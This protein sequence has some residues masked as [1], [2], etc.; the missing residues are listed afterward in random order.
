MLKSCR[1]NSMGSMC[2]EIRSEYCPGMKAYFEV[3]EPIPKL[4]N[5]ELFPVV[6]RKSDQNPLYQNYVFYSEQD[7]LTPLLKVTEQS[8]EPKFSGMV[9]L[10]FMENFLTSLKKSMSAWKRRKEQ[11]RIRQARFISDSEALDYGWYVVEI[12]VR[13][14]R[15]STGVDK[16]ATSFVPQITASPGV[17]NNV[18]YTISYPLTT[19]HVSDLDLGSSFAATVSLA[20]SASV[21]R[22]SSRSLSRGG[23]RG[24]RG[25]ERSSS[26][27]GKKVYAPAKKYDDFMPSTFVDISLDD[28]YDLFA[29]KVNP[30]IFNPFAMFRNKTFSDPIG[31]TNTEYYTMYP[32]YGSNLNSSF[33]KKVRKQGPILSQPQLIFVLSYSLIWQ[34]LPRQRQSKFP[35]SR[36]R[37]Y[38]MS[39]NPQIASSCR[40]DGTGSPFH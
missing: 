31:R 27:L 34:L 36:K 3:I 16:A 22:R 6:A 20:A 32:M 10:L 38:F 33:S 2:Q 14:A 30:R 24:G 28:R 39:M 18:V 9:S 19:D 26:G 25:L 29:Q 12:T 23:G 7:T 15:L 40:N 35:V 1:S 21:D 37:S 17:V 4:F 5:D 11:E 13:G 8:W